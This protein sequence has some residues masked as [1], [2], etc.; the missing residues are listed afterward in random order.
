MGLEGELDI[1]AEWYKNGVLQK[2]M[3]RGKSILVPV[4]LYRLRMRVPFTYFSDEERR[5]TV[6]TIRDSSGVLYHGPLAR[7]DG[8][9]DDVLLSLGI[10]VPK[11]DLRPPYTFF[12]RFI[13]VSDGTLAINNRSAGVLTL[14]AIAAYSSSFLARWTA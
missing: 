12:E 10:A 5:M 14:D 6:V 1:S 11:K 2:S 8:I 7:S 4:H 3:L 9:D 13:Q